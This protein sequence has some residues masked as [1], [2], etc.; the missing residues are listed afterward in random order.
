[1]FSFKKKKATKNDKI[2]VDHGHNDIRVYTVPG[3]ILNMKIKK[4][5]DESKDKNKTEP[6]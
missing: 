4:D 1:M 2:I 3:Q 5:E 6:K